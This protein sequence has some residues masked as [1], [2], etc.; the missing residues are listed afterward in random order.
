MQPMGFFLARRTS[1]V[2]QRVLV[3]L[4]DAHG[5]AFCQERLNEQRQ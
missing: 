4:Q 2:S 5:R 1:M 3:S